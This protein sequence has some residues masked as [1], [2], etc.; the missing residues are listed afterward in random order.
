MVNRTEVGIAEVYVLSA[1]P[2][3]HKLRRCPADAPN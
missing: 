2:V 1:L 3:I